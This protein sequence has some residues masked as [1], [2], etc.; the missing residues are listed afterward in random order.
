MKKLVRDR[1]PS[2]LKENEIKAYRFQKASPLLYWKYLKKKLVEE[3]EE[4]EKDE[5]EEELADI[6]EVIDAI[7]ECKGWSYNRIKNVQAAKRTEKGNFSERIILE[8]LIENQKD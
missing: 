2:I 6:F 8:K 3:A 1:I 5:S 4:F 7:L